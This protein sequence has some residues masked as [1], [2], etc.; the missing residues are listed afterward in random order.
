MEDA[1][2]RVPE[3][4]RGLD[5]FAARKQVVA[6]LEAAGA[7]VKVEKHQHAVRHCYRCDTV[8]E[9]RLSEQWFV[10]MAPLAAPA[11]AGVRDGTVR[12]LPE[13]WEAVYVNWLTN[14]RDWNISRQIWWG[15][16]VPVWYCDACPA[17]DN[18]FASRTDLTAC[19]RCGGVVRQDE[20][21]LDT[22][23]S[24]WL[25]PLSTLGWPNEDSRDLK[26]FY[27]TDMLVTAPEILFFWVARMIMAGY[28][29][30]GEA[31][32]HTVYLH[33][34][35][36][37][38]QHRKMSKSLGNGVDPLDVVKLYGADA[39]RW[40]LVAGMGLGTDVILDPDDLD[41][42]FA[43]GRN[44]A[45]KLWNIGRF[46]LQNVGTD[47][48]CRQKLKDFQNQVLARREAMKTRMRQ[49]DLPLYNEIGGENGKAYL[50]GDEKSKRLAVIDPTRDPVVVCPDPFY[51]I[52]EGAALLAGAQ[53]YYVASD[54]RRNFAVDW[55]GY[56]LVRDD[57]RSRVRNLY[58]DL[59]RG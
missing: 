7:L 42:S 39:L 35:V 9:P 45:T 41:K 5:R 28:E 31:P 12:I 46:L 1:A 23:F 43:P 36:R 49:Y 58:E 4:L 40:T 3:A 18:V 56:R 59:S 50:V 15:H 33:G 54:P 27:P 22:W 16:R 52:Y 6:M 47:P 34:T 44:F 24:S 30:R 37:D 53:P 51:Q 55:D 11:L 25:W 8:V 19:P 2:G 14:I 38:T 21:V 17:P 13:R 26:A 48:G 20:D 29:F 32:F 10:R 57:I